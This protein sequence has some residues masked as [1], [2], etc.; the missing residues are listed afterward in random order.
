MTTPARTRFLSNLAA[1]FLSGDWAASE[2]R[3]AAARAT[4]QRLRWV[5]ALAKR[6]VARFPEQP[7][8]ESLVEFVHSDLAVARACRGMTGDDF[9]VHTIFTHRAEMRPS[10]AAL[11]G[12]DLPQLPTS[13]AVAEWLGIT[14]NRL[15][16]L[17]DPT[18]RNR[19]HNPPLRTYRH[20]W[21]P[22]R[23]GRPRLLE[24]PGPLLKHAQRKILDGLLHRIPTHPAAHGF[25]PGR[26]AITNAA[27]HCG[28]TVVIRFDLADF[29]PSVPIGRVYALFRTLGY[30]ELVARLLAGLCTTRLPA[31]VWK[32]RPNPALDG[33][34]HSTWQRLSARHLPQG[35]PTSPA[36]ANLVAYRLDCRL[37]GLAAALDATY[38]RYADDLTIS[39]G[40]EL[41]RGARRLAHLVAVIAGEEGFTLHHRKT[42]VERRGGRQTV[43][44]VIVN[45]RPNFPRAE[46][47]CLK[48]ILTN[49]IRHG[50]ADQNR[51]GRMDF[52]AYL[53]GKVAHAAAINP[54]RGRKLWELFDRIAW[55]AA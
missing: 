17:A 12:V 53:A 1:A 52:R 8:F 35:A 18:G 19:L 3:R 27:P 37:T 42:R 24:I 51:Q 30:P 28:R 6:A 16:W 25:R 46:F 39:G 2:L 5:A 50:P 20:R 10:P 41:A 4:G 11:V 34:D 21:V 55:P 49:C 32:A 36:I 26:S 38:T 13:A 9:P 44:G 7:S 45:R 22:R 31:D 23:H 29:F 40:P 14:T 33:T 48:A 43:T 15:D 54:S 47:D